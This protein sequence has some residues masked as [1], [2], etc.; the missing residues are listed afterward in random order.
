MPHS[1][2]GDNSLD[3]YEVMHSTHKNNGNCI[4]V[5]HFED[6]GWEGA[7]EIIGLREL[8]GEKPGMRSA[9]DSTKKHPHTK[10]HDEEMEV[11][12]NVKVESIVETLVQ[13]NPNLLP[14]G[15][16]DCLKF[17]AK[18]GLDILYYEMDDRILTDLPTLPQGQ[19]F[20][21]PSE[22]Q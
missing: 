5:S 2:A 14:G 22:L 8:V 4:I 7:S 10:G 12:D 18:H 9:N 21:C 16:M 19:T 1:V 13:K 3:E 6:K 11:L 17:L 20:L 15:S